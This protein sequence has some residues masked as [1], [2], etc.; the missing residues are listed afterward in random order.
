M[1]LRAVDLNLLVILDVLLDEAHVSRAARRL[2]LSQPAVSA[3]LQRCR[4]LLGDE[5]LDR[6]RGMMHRTPRADALRSQLKSMLAEVQNLIEP[7]E[8]PLPELQRVVRITS[9]DLP[10]AMI[11]GSLLEEL[12]RTAPHVSVV[13][14]P[15]HGAEAAA[16]ALRNGDADM[17]ISVFD[18]VDDE[19]ER[20]TLLEETYVVAMRCDHPAA[21]GFDLEAWLAWP[22]VVVSGRGE[23]RTP[24]DAQLAAM[25]RHRQV[26]LVVPTFQLV[27]DLLARTSLMALLPVHSLRWHRGD[28]LLQLE[29]PLPNPGFPLHLAWHSRQ[30]TDRGLRHVLS[31]VSAIFGRMADAGGG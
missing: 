11:A 28:S 14:Q 18:W 2:N 6:G 22:H 13:F 15:W 27:P 1:N 30:S 9:A 29:P 31:I 10:T 12:G 8:V 26:G 21:E 25:G 5:L 4:H 24:L 17:A 19:I 20:L 7:T 23:M 16:A 3:A